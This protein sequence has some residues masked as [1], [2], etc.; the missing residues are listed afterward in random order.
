MKNKL[1]KLIKKNNEVET[2]YSS[3]VVKLVRQ[4][5]SQDEENAILRK[6]LANIDTKNEFVTY[7]AYVEECKVK[8]KQEL[9]I[10]Q[11][12]QK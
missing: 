4:K 9:E 12:T 11:N 5:Y 1:L 10:Q 3:L 8:A 6:K 7:N 2:A